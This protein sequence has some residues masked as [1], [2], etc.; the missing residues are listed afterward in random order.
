MGLPDL[1][2]YIYVCVQF[3][4]AEVICTKRPEMGWS[5][6]C[7]YIYV[8]IQFFLDEVLVY[9]TSRDG[10]TRCL[11]IHVCA[12]IFCKMSFCFFKSPEMKFPDV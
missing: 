11:G 3:M 12:C 9:K 7:V 1:S 10:L 2:V 6:A 8:C 4:K 5:D